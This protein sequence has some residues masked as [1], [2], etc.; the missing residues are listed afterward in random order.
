MTISAAKNPSEK[1]RWLAN[2]ERLE[3]LEREQL[4]PLALQLSSALNVLAS[5][6]D[7]QIEE[8]EATV[9]LQRETVGLP[10][11]KIGA[12]EAPKYGA[13]P[14]LAEMSPLEP[15]LTK[16][17]SDLAAPVVK[18]TAAAQAAHDDERVSEGFC[19][20]WKL[21]DG[22]LDFVNKVI[23]EAGGSPRSEKAIRDFMAREGF[24]E[25]GTSGCEVR[26]PRAKLRQVGKAMATEQLERTRRRTAAKTA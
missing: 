16:T 25:I 18:V 17:A 1:P 5:I 20:S 15:V 19:T 11:V 3:R 26:E 14:V 24:R 6:S 7:E 9:N 10:P 22:V 23:V 12:I 21:E 2:H 13:V 4:R 8:I